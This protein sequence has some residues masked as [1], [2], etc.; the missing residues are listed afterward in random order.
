MKCYMEIFEKI[1]EK[2]FNLLTNRLYGKKSSVDSRY[3]EGEIALLQW[4]C[5]LSE[6]YMKRE[7]ELGSEFVENIAK[8]MKKVEHM[9]KS[10]YR[11]GMKDIAALILSE[12]G[13]SV[14]SE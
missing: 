10:A 7:K 9:K 13:I 8:E 14:Y 2:A 4:L 3:L 5:R 1:N 12:S 6:Y 11:E